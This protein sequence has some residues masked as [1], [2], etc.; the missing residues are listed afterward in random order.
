MWDLGLSHD[1]VKMVLWDNT[2][3]AEPLYYHKHKIMQLCMS[4]KIPPIIEN[5]ISISMFVL[6]CW[7]VFIHVYEI[8][9][10]Y[11]EN[12]RTHQPLKP[13]VMES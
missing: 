12:G 8:W 5:R 6:L 4:A 3:T 7:C 2:R 10:L 1:C 13:I 11:M 9:G